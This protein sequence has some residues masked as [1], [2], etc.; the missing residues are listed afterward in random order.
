MLSIGLTLKTI[1]QECGLTFVF[2]FPQEN[3]ICVVKESDKS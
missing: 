2:G 1:S 3:L